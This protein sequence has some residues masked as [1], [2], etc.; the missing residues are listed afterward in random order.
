MQP[1][2][3]SPGSTMLEHF[4][5]GLSPDDDAELQREVTCSGLHSVST[6]EPEFKPVHSVF[7][8]A[9]KG[10]ARPTGLTWNLLSQLRNLPTPSCSPSIPGCLHYR[11]KALILSNVATLKYSSS[12]VVST[13][14]P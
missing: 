12:C 11:A 6:S 9:L 4:A 1:A 7:G 5:A 10:G 13:P 2:E 14:L 8:P 3:H